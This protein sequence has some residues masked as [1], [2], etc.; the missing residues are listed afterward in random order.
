MSGEDYYNNV[1]SK[2]T[3]ITI[4]QPN[5][6]L[7]IA[8]NIDNTSQYCKQYQDLNYDEYSLKQNFFNPNKF[9][10]PNE[11]NIRLEY[12]LHHNNSNNIHL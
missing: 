3:P 6:N 4:P 12:R 9:S 11:W 7:D 5:F 2:P 10:P 8:Y 1:N